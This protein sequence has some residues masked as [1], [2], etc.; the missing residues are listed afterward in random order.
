M[1]V[2]WRA[3]SQCNFEHSLIMLLSRFEFPCCRSPLC[4]NVILLFFSP[5]IKQFSVWPLAL[6]CLNRG[7]SRLQAAC[8]HATSTWAVIMGLVA[9][10]VLLCL[11]F[12]SITLPKLHRSHKCIGITWA[13]GTDSNSSFITALYIQ[14]QEKKKSKL[15]GK[16]LKLTRHSH[17]CFLF[18]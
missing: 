8:S 5:Q 2:T 12:R 3:V 10:E 18:L 1:L 13:V 7:N 11:H 4:C 14:K 17:Y 6:R 9:T 15:A 16:N